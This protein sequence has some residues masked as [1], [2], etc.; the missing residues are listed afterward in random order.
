MSTTIFTSFESTHR[1]K[2]DINFVANSKG[3]SIDMTKDPVTFSKTPSVEDSMNIVQM[4]NLEI[5]KDESCPLHAIRGYIKSLG[6]RGKAHAGP[7]P[8]DDAAD[9]CCELKPRDQEATSDLQTSTRACVDHARVYE[10]FAILNIVNEKWINMEICQDPF[11]PKCCRLPMRRLDSSCW[12]ESDL[13]VFELAEEMT[14]TRLQAYD[15]FDFR[16]GLQFGEDEQGKSVSFP[17]YTKVIIRR[18]RPGHS[19]VDHMRRGDRLADLLSR[20]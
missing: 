5:H 9:G 7:S 10:R 15:H 20:T 17:S 16:S 8:H 18:E 14:G 4:M 6:E 11:L 12:D 3:Q 1:R 19:K 13:P 2:S